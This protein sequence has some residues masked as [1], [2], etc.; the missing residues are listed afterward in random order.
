MIETSDNKSEYCPHKWE[1]G[2]IFYYA[3]KEKNY[4]ETPLLATLL[5]NVRKENKFW[6]GKKE[7]NETN[8]NAKRQKGINAYRQNL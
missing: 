7:L 6:K 1:C 5:F 2:G 3:G 4:A 8:K